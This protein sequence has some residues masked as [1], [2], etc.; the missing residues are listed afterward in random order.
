MATLGDCLYMGAIPRAEYMESAKG[1]VKTDNIAGYIY[2]VA[3]MNQGCEISVFVEGGLK[4]LSFGQKV[5]I[6]DKDGNAILNIMG[7]ATN[8]FVNLKYSIKAED[9]RIAGTVAKSNDKKL[10]AI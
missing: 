9:I 2:K 5:E 10:V 4:N 3:S 1:K 8:N 7:T 6:G